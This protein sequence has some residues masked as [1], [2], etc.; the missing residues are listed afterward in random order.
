MY[1]TYCV[2]IWTKYIQL[3]SIVTELNQPPFNPVFR[4]L[5]P[6]TSLVGRTLELFRI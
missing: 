3:H 1:R 5:L 4:L 2:P 6:T